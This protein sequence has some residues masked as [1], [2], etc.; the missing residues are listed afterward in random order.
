[1]SNEIIP[2]KEIYSNGAWSK[3]IS[4]M[5]GL[6]YNGPGKVL[7]KDVSKSNIEK[8]TYALVKI[9]KTTIC[10]T[11]LVIFQGKTRSIKPGTTLGHEGVG[12]IEE[13]GTSVS[14]FKK[15]ILPNWPKN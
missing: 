7:Y 2:V 5:K 15:A 6:V 11:D 4:I 13:V 14:H 8:P 12:I 9:V 1:M 3:N 10:G